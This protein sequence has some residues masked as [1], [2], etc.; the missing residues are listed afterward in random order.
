MNIRQRITRYVQ[1]GGFKAH[2]YL[3]FAWAEVILWIGIC[4]LVVCGLFD[5]TVF[6]IQQK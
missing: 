3:F 4:T 5:L 6:L 1:V 2:S